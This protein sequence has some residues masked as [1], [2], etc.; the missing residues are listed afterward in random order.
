MENPAI[1]EAYEKAGGRAQVLLKLSVSKQTLSDWK[2]NGEV[3]ARHAIPLE[4]LS[5]VSRR[6]LCPTFNWG[7]EKAKAT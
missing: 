7:P 2:R 6:R 3:P 4:L 5:G 1:E